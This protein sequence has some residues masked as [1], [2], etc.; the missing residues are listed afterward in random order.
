MIVNIS[1]II[2]S[3]NDESKLTL[4]LSQIPSWEAIPNEIL[5][6]DSSEK[7]PNF[8]KE[9]RSFFEENKIRL[10]ISHQKNLFPGHA[11]NIGIQ[12]SSNSL[13]AF[14]DTSTCPTKKWLSSGIRLMNEN[15]SNGVWGR[16]YY[17]ADEFITK[18]I[19][20]CTYGVNPIVTFPGTILKKRIFD[21]CGLFIE[22]T[23]SGE[24]GDWMTRA[25]LQNID[26]VNSKEIL[27]YDKLNNTGIIDLIK[28]WFRNYTYSSRLPHRRRHKDYYYYGL[29]IFAVLFAYNW[30][31]ILAAWDTSSIFYIPN[32]TKISIFF[33]LFTYV[34]FRGIFLPR[35]K[36]VKYGFIFPIN[37][38]FVVLLSA[39]L[40][41]TK[42]L[43]FLNS[44]VIKK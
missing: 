32:I 2:P 3:H 17:Q 20:A 16:T 38:I 43:A 23:R 24:D 4:L 19:R 26:M 8:S 11:R 34:S 15:N 10:Q 12:N 18:I 40:D 25:N 27:Q 44:K 31:R 36:G 30:N 21:R 14:L 5:I 39:L 22:S 33:I 28:K 37:F 1:L 29:S 13:L 35:K 6:V 42:V 41:I 9:F 7:K